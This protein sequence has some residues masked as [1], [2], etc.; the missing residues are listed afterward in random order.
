M[1]GLMLVRP[2][3]PSDADG[4]V[5]VLALLP[6]Y[7][8]PSTHDAVRHGISHYMTLVA[9]DGGDVVGFIVIERRH[10]RSAEITYAAVH[11]ARQV[12]GVGS[13]LLAAALDE[14]RAA[15]VAVV[16]VKTLDATAGYE[17]YVST[18]AFWERRGFVQIDCIDPLPGW[19]P[20]NPSAIYVRALAAT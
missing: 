11:P 9:D 13:L 7:F 17:P 19:D 8:T 10:V 16:E 2:A 1:V 18:R 5:G 12:Q 14:L 3:L 20:G 6:E 15:G 4:C